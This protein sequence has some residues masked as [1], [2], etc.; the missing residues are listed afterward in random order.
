MVCAS[1][2]HRVN[3]SDHAGAVV[4]PDKVL[5]H[6]SCFSISGVMLA[7]EQEFVPEVVPALM[8]RDGFL[9]QP[10]SS[11][12]PAIPDRNAGM[13]GNGSDFLAVSVTI[14]VGLNIMGMD[15]MSARIR[16]RCQDERKENNDTFHS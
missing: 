4:K 12:S 15:K 14:Q 9:R 5:D 3:R 1:G 8:E 7:Q 13:R 6:E 2:V 16:G 11:R 10:E